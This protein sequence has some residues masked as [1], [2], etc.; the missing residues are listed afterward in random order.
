MKDELA[1]WIPFRVKGGT[2]IK[3]GPFHSREQALRERESMKAH[4]C[5]VDIYWYRTPAEMDQ[6]IQ[7]MNGLSK[8]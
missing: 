7:E 6:M 1:Y 2:W 3:T 4:D 8:P 5:E